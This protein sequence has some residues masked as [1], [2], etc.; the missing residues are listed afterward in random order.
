[1]KE[2]I[3]TFIAI[4]ITPEKKLNELTTEFKR[5]LKMEEIRWV[6]TQNL[7]LTLRFL[8]ETSSRQISDVVQLLE[9]VSDHFEPFK[10]NLRGTGFFKSKGQPKVLHFGVD[11]DSYL[12][13]LVKEIEQGLAGI[14]FRTEEKEFRP[15]LTMGR[16]KYIS[17]K[18][19]FQ[20]LVKKF[21]NYQIQEVEAT[22]VIFYQSILGSV[23]PTYIPIK[24]FQFRN[25]A[26]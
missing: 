18:T 3:R 14:G 9:S 2:T 13:E 5:S 7:H 19:A 4:K 16:M 21:G 22:E 23:G 17:D 15:H 6:D 8:G 26:Q 1:M 24:T 10:F 12:K 11:D 25:S 20:A